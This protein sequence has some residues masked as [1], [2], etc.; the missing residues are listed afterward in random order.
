MMPDSPAPRQTL[1]YLRRRFAESGIHPRT[2]L[3]QNFLTDANLQGLLVSAAALG[4]DDVVLEVGT[5]TGSVTILMAPQVAAVVT[6]E[7]DRQLYQLAAEELDRFS[8]VRMLQCDALRRKNQVN[9]EVLAAV[10]REL[11]AAPGRRF[12]VVANLPYVIATPLLSNLVALDR[13]PHSMTVTIQKEVADRIVSPPGSRDYGALS[14]WMQSQ[15]QVELVRQLPPSVFW[16][17]PKVTSAIVR[18][19]LDEARRAQIPDREFFHTFIRALFIHRR[20]FLR[21]EL[22]AAFKGRLGKADVDAI[23]A[24]TGLAPE[25][26]AEQ[27]DVATMLALAEAVRARMAR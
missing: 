25:L 26:R 1:S 13:P 23:L 24:E 27:L 18:I 19:V 12:Q 11:A 9:P 7:I 16:P 5:G 4:R 10:E 3:G 6:V 21:S 15:C 14:I 17:R 22:V 20:K 2:A 8:N